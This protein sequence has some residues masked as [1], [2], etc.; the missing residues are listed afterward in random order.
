MT[1]LKVLSLITFII[2]SNSVISQN[3]DSQEFEDY[4]KFLPFVIKGLTKD[5][6]P[7]KTLDG[8]TSGVFKKPWNIKKLQ[9]SEIENIM[10]KLVENKRFKV[11]K[12]YTDEWKLRFSSNF[13]TFSSFEEIRESNAN[14]SNTFI[15]VSEIE[16]LDENNISVYIDDYDKTLR[17][18]ES[19]ELD[20]NG[21]QINTT[22][23]IKEELSTLK[24]NITIT[25][26]EYSSVKYKELK[27]TEND[28]EF[29]IGEVKGI[30]LLKVLENRAYFILPTKLDDIEITA[31]NI[32]KERFTSESKL[33][34]PKKVYDFA[35]NN[36]ITD[37]TI[38]SFIDKLSI[39]D[40]YSKPQIL[41]FETNG[42]IENL[43][44]YI[45][46]QEVNLGSKKVEI[47]L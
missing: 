22:F 28:V 43:Y 38:K 35:K 42:N 26:N 10:N 23:Q 2:F 5:D 30:K 29:K 7:K 3:N 33:Y 37:E 6:K 12:D 25:L 19:K 17:S 32:K 20:F 9:S 44:F 41:I 27:K 45:K 18:N 1:K 13:N 4:K 34:I 21:G 39:D 31:T 11:R 16:I 46:S 8:E 36:N 40:V 15:K 14:L 24:G 47:K